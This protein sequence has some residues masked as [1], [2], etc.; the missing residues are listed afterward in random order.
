MLLSFETWHR[1]RRILPMCTLVAASRTGD[2][3]SVLEA[4]A[5]RLEKLGGRVMLMQYDALPM[6]SREI[7]KTYSLGGSAADLLDESVAK[8]VDKLGLYR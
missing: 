4:K 2:D 6:S 8:I 5:K 1:F 7:R 3:M